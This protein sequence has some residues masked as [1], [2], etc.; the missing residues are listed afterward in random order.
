MTGPMLALVIGLAITFTALHAIDKLEG[1]GTRGSE[2]PRGVGPAAG[3]E[4]RCPARAP[5]RRHVVRQ[6]GRW[7]EKFASLLLTGG[8]LKLK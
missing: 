3:A 1:P 8:S 4:L 6:F 2:S 7:S 5:R